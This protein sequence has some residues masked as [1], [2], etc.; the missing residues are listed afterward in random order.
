MAGIMALIN[1]KYGP[2][3]QANF[4]LYPLAAQHPSAFHDV[5]VGSNIV[6]CQQ[7]S[8][9]CTLSTANDNTN[10]YYTL[11]YYAG[12]GYDLATG[13]GSVDAN[14]LFSNWNSLSFESTSTDLTLGQTSFTHGTPVLV[15][16]GVSGSGGTPT[17]GVELVTTAA[18]E[19][20]A[21]LKLLTLQGGAASAN[22][23][24]LP[25][26]KYSV[27]A[28]Y[29]GDSV[30]AS[31]TSNPVSVNVTPEASNLSMFGS[32]YLY[33]NGTTGVLANG[34]TYP[35]G[36][37]IAIDA[38]L[39]GVNAPPGSTDGIATGTATFT[40]AASA[41]TVSSG[42]QSMG[43]ASTAVWVPAAFSVGD[44]S[45]SASYSGDASFNASASTTPLSF[46]ITKAIPLLSCGH[47]YLQLRAVRTSPSS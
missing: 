38:Q 28:R 34:G 41:G 25:G 46:T 5:T 42:P 8:P 12:P 31:S 21:G 36:T 43:T 32:Y 40:D 29:G 26:G 35:F 18:P 33:T 9:N 17:G 16:V 6:P 23:N 44:H 14:Q 2:Q 39:V 20:N 3:G 1:Q 37:S 13:W 30:F 10:G 7:G 47:P 27:S 22:V 45:I 11:G 15:N 19:N 4:I 24:S